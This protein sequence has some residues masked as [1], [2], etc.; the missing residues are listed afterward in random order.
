M[1]RESPKPTNWFA[2]ATP[3]ADADLRLFCLPHVGGSASTFRTWPGIFPTNIAVYPIELPGRGTRFRE[4]AID[5]LPLLTERLAEA[6]H[7]YLDRPFALFGHSMGAL[8]G[9]ELARRLRRDHGIC[10][11]TLVVSAYRAPHLSAPGI[12]PHILSD[13]DLFQ[14]VRALG[15]TPEE[16]LG[17]GKLM[18]LLLA[19]IRADLE[20]CETYRYIQ[21]PPLPCAIAA[22]GGNHDSS[23]SYSD[24][25]AW[26]VHTSSPFSLRMFPGKHFYFRQTP[27]SLLAW[28]EQTISESAT[29]RQS[30]K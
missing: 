20:L 27:L 19:T 13:Q 4:K 11:E 25:A 21:E 3:H 23:V 26:Q 22:C 10:P 2:Y 24:L 18:H 17:R 8:I 12:E 6:L 29:D 5:R 14:R 16:I 1:R 30:T 15:G 7:P 9:F 28:L